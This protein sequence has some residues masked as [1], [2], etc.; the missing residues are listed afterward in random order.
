[1]DQDSH[2]PQASTEAEQQSLQTTTPAKADLGKRFIAAVID[3]ALA[4]VVSLIP[5]V[6]GIVGGLY[7]LLRDGLDYE[8]LRRRSV[9]K[10]LMKL[11]PVRLDGQPMDI[12]TSVKRNWVFS[13]GLVASIL[14][15]IPVIGWIAS[16]LLIP[17]S[18]ILSLVEG[19]LVLTDKEGRRLGDK[20][21]TTRVIEVA[22]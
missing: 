5:V 14:L 12:E 6:G 19:I 11:R 21:A 9:G 22:E 8:Y 10:T 2:T 3:G 17:I 4:S 20:M 18:G 1:M 16:L 7:I 15:L 13:L